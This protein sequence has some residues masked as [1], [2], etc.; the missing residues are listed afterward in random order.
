M[1]KETKVGALKCH[2]KNNPWSKS[3]LARRLIYFPEVKLLKNL[4][5]MTLTHNEG[6][7]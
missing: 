6:K 4:L 1:S 3:T 5:S 2:V 7:T